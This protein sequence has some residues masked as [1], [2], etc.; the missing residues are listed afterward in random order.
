MEAFYFIFSAS[1]CP[2]VNPRVYPPLL[3]TAPIKVCSAQWD[4][5]SELILGVIFFVIEN[6]KKIELGFSY[7]SCSISMQTTPVIITKT[8]GKDI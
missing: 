8:L 3:C 4:S 2:E 1:T 5:F 6:E 7:F